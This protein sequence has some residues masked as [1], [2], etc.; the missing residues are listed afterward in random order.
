MDQQDVSTGTAFGIGWG[1]VCLILGKVVMDEGG[2]RSDA[3]AL[4]EF[5]IDLE[6]AGTF[7][8][9]LTQ[10][11]VARDFVRARVGNRLGS[12]PGGSA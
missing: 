1:A 9:G 10:L 4:E 7:A 6:Q 5:F 11:T 3:E 8:D 12:E 2:D